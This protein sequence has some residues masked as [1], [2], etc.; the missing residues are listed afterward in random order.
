MR[1]VQVSRLMLQQVCRCFC[2]YGRQG[3]FLR[4]V[5]VSWVL[6]EGRFC[7]CGRQGCLLQQVCVKRMLLQGRVSKHGRQEKEEQEERQQDVWSLWQQLIDLT[8]ASAE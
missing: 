2:F 6:L 7:F 3:R 8:S 5:E 1:Q 4:Q